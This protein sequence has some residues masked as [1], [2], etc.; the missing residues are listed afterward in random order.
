MMSTKKTARNITHLNEPDKSS[1][2][3]RSIL[4]A[5][6]TKQEGKFTKKRP[7][8]GHRNR[9]IK[10]T[11][12]LII[13]RRIN[14]NLDIIK[15]SNS[16]YKPAINVYKKLNWLKDGEKKKRPK[17]RSGAAFHSFKR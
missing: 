5:K 9:N 17:R 14:C 7:C 12:E 1:S 13:Q 16:Y 4:V 11:F 6:Q 2:S 10:M 15:S 3:Q 8:K